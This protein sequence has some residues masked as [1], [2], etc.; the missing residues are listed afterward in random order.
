M[1]A[2][3]TA[4]AEEIAWAGGL[5]EGEGCLGRYGNV[6][7]MR[8]HSTDEDVVRRFR[9]VVERGTV[10]GPY[11]NSGKDGSIRKPFWAWV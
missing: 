4:S 10:Y 5:F 1:G 9:D 7:V 6:F 11:E 2:T 3:M 8:I